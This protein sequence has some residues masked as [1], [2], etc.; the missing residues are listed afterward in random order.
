MPVAGK[1]GV[2][3][4]NYYPISKLLGPKSDWYAALGTNEKE[5]ERVARHL[6]NLLTPPLMRE[7]KWEALCLPMEPPPLA[8][9]PPL[10]ITPAT[11]LAEARQFAAAFVEE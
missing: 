9:P 7:A 11:T 2:R 3:E 1:P 10:T 5:R 8:A 4:V 6:W